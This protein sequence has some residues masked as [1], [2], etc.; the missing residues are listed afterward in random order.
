MHLLKWLHRTEMYVEC[1][2]MF[3]EKSLPGTNVAAK[4]RLICNDSHQSWRSS[5]LVQLIEASVC[6]AVLIDLFCPPSHPVLDL[7]QSS[8]HTRTYRPTLSLTSKAGRGC[9]SGKQ[10]FT[11][12]P[13]SQLKR[14][15]GDGECSHLCTVWSRGW[16]MKERQPIALWVSLFFP[17]M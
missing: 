14:K 9:H 12:T 4:T 3:T 15:Q 16:R 1:V 10:L 13:G 11:L 17:R 2:S 6:R 7:P 8:T 5:Q